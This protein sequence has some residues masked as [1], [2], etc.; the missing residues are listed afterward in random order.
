MV[1]WPKH[2]PDPDGGPGAGPETA[3]AAPE[4]SVVATGECGVRARIHR[5]DTGRAV[6]GPGGRAISGVGA[7]APLGD[8]E[9]LV[10]RTGNVNGNGNDSAGGEAT[11][12]VELRPGREPDARR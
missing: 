9:V 7:D 10:E 6:A 3:D 1:R 12:G 8:Q 4:L 5:A 11:T 2:H